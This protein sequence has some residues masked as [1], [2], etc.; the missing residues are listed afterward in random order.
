MHKNEMGSFFCQFLYFFISVFIDFN[1]LCILYSRKGMSKNNINNKILRCL[2]LNCYFRS[3]IYRKIWFSVSLH[4]EIP[5]VF[6]FANAFKCKILMG[7]I[8]LHTVFNYNYWKFYSKLNQALKLNIWHK[9]YP[10]LYKS[11]RIIIFSLHNTV[12]D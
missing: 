2:M 11:W 8:N 6:L 3:S 12:P 5:T 4:W 10:G 1:D 7:E 9:F